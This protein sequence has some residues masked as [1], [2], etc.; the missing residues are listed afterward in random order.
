ME[1]LQI[2]GFVALVG[3]FLA[4]VPMLLDLFFSLLAGDYFE[5]APLTKICAALGLLLV[6]VALLG[7][8]AIAVFGG[9][10]LQT[11]QTK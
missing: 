2:I 6:V 7:F 1:L 4:F 3:L 9:L 5:P 11:I 10:D 8:L